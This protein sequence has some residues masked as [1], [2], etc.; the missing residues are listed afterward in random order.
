MGRNNGQRPNLIPGGNNNPIE[1]V[2]AGCEG[3]DTAGQKLGTPELYYDPCQFEPSVHGFFGNL[4]K[5]TM[6][7]PGIAKFDF[8]IFKN[9]NVTE[10]NRVQFRA[11]FFNLFNRPIFGYPD[12]SPW[13]S[14]GRPDG[15][16]GKISS[17]RDTARQIQFGLKF[18]F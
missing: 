17:T 9:I 12:K 14:R 5:T 16:A 8:S 11:E 15:N 7:S 3:F 2:S 10:N 1:G 6:T 18:L 13:S 4:G